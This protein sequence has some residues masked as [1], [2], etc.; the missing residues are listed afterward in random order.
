MVITTVPMT[1]PTDFICYQQT[2][3]LSRRNEAAAKKKVLP[4]RAVLKYAAEGRFFFYADP[5]VYPA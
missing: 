4:D 2:A 1:A 3:F 5:E